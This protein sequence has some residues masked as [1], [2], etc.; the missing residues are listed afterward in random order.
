MQTTPVDVAAAERRIE[1]QI[2]EARALA[3][4]LEAVRLEAKRQ[5]DALAKKA[6]GA[7]AKK[8]LEPVKRVRLQR[9]NIRLPLH[10][11]RTEVLAAG[12]QQQ[13]HNEERCG[14]GPS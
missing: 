14:P 4:R 1:R 9:S 13:R 7:L 8:A 11:D 3:V 6:L 10:H 12:T 2:E 5:A